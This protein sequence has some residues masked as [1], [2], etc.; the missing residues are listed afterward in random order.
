MKTPTIE[1]LKY[2]ESIRNKKRYGGG[3]RNEMWVVYNRIFGTNDRPTSCGS[4][5]AKVHRRLMNV[6]NQNK[7]LLNG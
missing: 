7:Q 4:C 2:I 5:V 6:Y 1:E 3:D